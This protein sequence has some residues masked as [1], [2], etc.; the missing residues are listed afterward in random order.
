MIEFCSPNSRALLPTFRTD[1]RDPLILPR[2]GLILPRLPLPTPVL[3]SAATNPFQGY[4]RTQKN[5]PTPPQNTPFPGLNLKV[6]K[7]NYRLGKSDPNGAKCLKSGQKFKKWA[8]LFYSC[9]LSGDSGLG[10]GLD[11]S[12]NEDPSGKKCVQRC[13]I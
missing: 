5:T 12:E 10:I 9:I 6:G 11:Q 8:N 13:E 7:M 1:C 2:W 3:Y 4:V